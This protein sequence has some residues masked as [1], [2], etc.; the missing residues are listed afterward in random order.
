MSARDS[1]AVA[2][3]TI[4][5]EGSDS[6]AC[7]EGDTL[8]KSALRAGIGMGYECNVGACGSCK[9]EL[10]EGEVVDLWPEAP[11][12]S[13]R[14][15]ARGRRLA[16]Q[17]VPVSDCKL[18]TR[19]AAAFVPHVQPR[20]QLWTF[21]AREPVTHDISRFRFEPQD[22]TAHPFLPGQ[23]ALLRLPGVNAPRAYSFS[24]V[25]RDNDASPVWEFMVRHVPGGAATA[26]LFGALQ[27]GASVEIDGPYGM[28]FLR[29][30]LP[31]ETVCIAGGSG[32][33]PVVSILRALS[34]SVPAA[35]EPN[36]M[37]LLYGARHVEDL[38]PA[39]LIDQLSAGIR[40]LQ[41]TQVLSQADA[42]G[43]T[44]WQGPSGFVHE[45]VARSLALP[46][47]QYEYYLA[48]PPPMIEATLKLLAL[49]HRVPQEQIH[50]DR[51]F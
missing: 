47:A 26:C 27:T 25:V 7:T 16:C 12:L 42:H 14:D 45:W 33:A 48:G 13:A 21:V 3:H 10:L 46:L 15:R 24:N 22:A 41:H 36:T 50:Y 29:A 2:A 39:A 30:G 11:G 37:H 32:L 19:T 1:I 5:L 51:F 23:Y 17:S 6:F 9:V 35:G 43:A 38:L 34:A 40:Q 20:K 44:T 31:R 4:S 18:R 28:A 8:L 49:E